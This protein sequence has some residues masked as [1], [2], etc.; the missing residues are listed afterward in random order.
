MITSN[1]TVEEWIKKISKGIEDN[2]RSLDTMK[3]QL[4]LLRELKEKEELE[5]PLN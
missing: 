1:Y 5:A 2:Q 3:I 4:E